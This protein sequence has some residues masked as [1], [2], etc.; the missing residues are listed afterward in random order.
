MEAICAQEN[1][2]AAVRAVKRNK[3]TPGVDGMTVKRLPE[4]PTKR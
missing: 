4:M 1:V 2:E 3:G